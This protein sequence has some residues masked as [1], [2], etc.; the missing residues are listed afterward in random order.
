MFAP[1]DTAAPP[2]VEAPLSYVIGPVLAC[3]C[4]PGLG[5]AGLEWSSL[6]S[7]SRFAS[8]CP[9]CGADRATGHTW[10]HPNTP[11]LP[12]PCT[13]HYLLIVRYWHFGMQWLA[14]HNLH[15]RLLPDF[16]CEKG[17]LIDQRA[18]R[19]WLLASGIHHNSL[20]ASC[21]GCEQNSAAGMLRLR[22]ARNGRAECCHVTISARHSPV[23]QQ[24]RRRLCVTAAVS[25]NGS[26][27]PLKVWRPP[28]AHWHSPER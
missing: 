25:S 23:K 12:G 24:G 27:Q 13:F 22:R 9:F 14:D 15:N 5:T 18:A 28:T 19:W 3:C 10:A 17:S 21:A 20:E 4:W 26:G 1:T 6:T 16:G 11:N 8:L 7:S 2:A